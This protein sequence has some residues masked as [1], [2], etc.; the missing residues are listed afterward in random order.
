MGLVARS[1]SKVLVAASGAVTVLFLLLSC[2]HDRRQ[3]S[4]VKAYKPLQAKTKLTSVAP[5]AQL[6]EFFADSLTIG[7]RKR[8][9][10]TI[11]NYY[12][13]DSQ[14]VDIRFYA[15]QLGHWKLRSSFHFQKDDLTGIDPVLT[16]FNHDGLFDFTYASAVAARGAN[17]VQRLFLY[18]HR[19]DQLLP[20][21]NAQDYP[22]LLY[23]KH[24]NC[25]DAF[26]LHGGCTTFF[27]KISG[28]SLRE[29]ARVDLSDSLIVRA[30][31]QYGRGKVLFRNLANTAEYI[32][33]KNY[34]PLQVY[35]Q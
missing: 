35:P 26:A 33:Y 9:K 17:R 28:D 20:I 31:D 24:L 3:L 27:L 10:I 16:D 2:H 4:T 22:N 25:L 14:Y 15:R 21:R 13:P 30:Y 18:D 6:K 32:R 23:N 29:F 7:H 34:N 19:H 1:Y 12:T 8:H 11:A 5:T